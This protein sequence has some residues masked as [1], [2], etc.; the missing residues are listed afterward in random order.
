MHMTK[1]STTLVGLAL[2]GSAGVASAE[3]VTYTI[4]PAQSTL[5]VTGNLTGG[6]ASQQSPGSLTTSYSGAVAANRTRRSHGRYAGVTAIFNV[7]LSEFV[8]YRWDADVL[9]GPLIW[10]VMI[11]CAPAMISARTITIDV[12]Y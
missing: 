6:F 2:F 9:G 12:I 1:L 3:L 7:H 11:T 8:G 4:V 10:I 5:T